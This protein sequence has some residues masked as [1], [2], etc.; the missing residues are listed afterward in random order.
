MCVRGGDCERE[1]GK[2]HQEREENR[3]EALRKRGGEEG[4]RRG[5]GRGILVR[6]SLSVRRPG[7]SFGLAEPERRGCG[8]SRGRNVPLQASRLTYAAGAAGGGARRSRV[9]ATPEGKEMRLEW[10]FGSLA[11]AGRASTIP[12]PASAALS[13][14]SITPRVSAS[15]IRASMFVPQRP[16]VLQLH[17]D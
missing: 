3:R 16:M 8:R 14:S 1:K 6:V 10:R 12:H 17:V 13:A 5:A 7:S 11:A 4:R 15:T 2:K 9:C